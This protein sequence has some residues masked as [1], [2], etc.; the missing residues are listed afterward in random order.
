M[1]EWY[2]QEFTFGN[3]KNRG[4]LLLR[5]DNTGEIVSLMEDSL[6]GTVQSSQQQVRKTCHFLMIFDLRTSSNLMITDLGII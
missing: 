5:G 1:A 6:M 4:E 3:F 2:N